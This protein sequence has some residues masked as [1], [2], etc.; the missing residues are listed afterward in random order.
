MDALISGRAGVALIRRDDSLVSV[1]V[2]SPG[3]PV[4]RSVSDWNILLG[5]ARDLRLLED[6]TLGEVERTLAEVHKRATALDLTL[7]LLDVKL[8]AEVRRDA[9]SE[10]EVLIQDSSCLESLES[11]LY[12]A[13]SPSIVNLRGAV[14]YTAAMPKTRSML[15]ALL[16]HQLTIGEVVAA[17]RT[18]TSRVLTEMD[19]EDWERL[20]QTVV[21]SGLFYLLSTRRSGGGRLSVALAAAKRMPG[22][23]DMPIAERVLTEWVKL[24]RRGRKGVR[25]SGRV[26]VRSKLPT[27]AVGTEVLR[28]AEERFTALYPLITRIASQLIR[29]SVPPNLA[30]EF[31]SYV[32]EKLIEDDYRRIRNF[33]DLQKVERYLQV[34]LRHLLWDY[35]DQRW[36]RWRSSKEAERLGPVAM[37]IEDYWVRDGLTLDQVHELLVTNHRVGITRL[38]LEAIAARLPQR[39]RRR[40]ESDES[41]ANEPSAETAD[42]NLHEQERRQLIA[43]A[44]AVIMAERAALPPEDAL[45]VSLRLD[46]GLPMSKIA[47]ILKTD[48]KPLYSRLE[49]ILAR[50]RRALEEVGVD[51]EIIRNLLG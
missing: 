44:W 26:T 27:A 48:P 1:H 12:A 33:N 31:R 32:Y 38:E 35:R 22:V 16:A 25:P 28:N 14:R 18:V 2:G 51:A 17:W 40:I 23:R 41:L 36:G 34:V 29:S 24:L 46:D 5:H 50:L 3:E 45:F 37:L 9:A 6:T 42:G 39:V 13:P 30:D 19:R 20:R 47:S 11:V 43:R 10:L 21:E 7:I 15:S 8:S 4:T 49:K